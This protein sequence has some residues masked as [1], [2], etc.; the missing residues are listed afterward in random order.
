MAS[1]IHTKFTTDQVK[2]LLTKY[3][4]NE[5]ERKYMQQMLG[6]GKSRFFE[7]LQAYRANPEGF[8]VDYR[9][10]STHPP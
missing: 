3:L 1:Q 7:L 10:L 8:S 4:K 6:I 2:E 5:V 9:E